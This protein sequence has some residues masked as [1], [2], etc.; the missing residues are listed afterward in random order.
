MGVVARRFTGA[1]NKFD[2]ER[3][4]RNGQRQDQR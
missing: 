2:I 4:D 1:P 3:R